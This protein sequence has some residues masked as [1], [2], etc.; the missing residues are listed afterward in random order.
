MPYI[1]AVV[2]T[3]NRTAELQRL[4]ESVLSNG[5]VDLELIIVDQNRNFLIDTLIAEYNTRLNILH[6]KMEEANQSKARNYGAS[7]AKGSVLCFPDD[8][9][10]FEKDSIK[11][12]SEYFGTPTAADLLIIHWKQN[13]VQGI[14][15][16]K[17]SPRFIY[18]FKAVGYATYVMFFK[19]E[20]YEALGG[21]M[22]TIGIGKYIGGGEDSE[23]LFRAAK[24]KFSIRYDSEID[25][26][27]IYIPVY[28]RDLPIIRARQRAMGLMY[29][30]YPVSPFVIFK[31][32]LSPFIKMITAARPE[33]K[34]H[35]NAGVG[36]VQGF[37]HGFTNSKLLFKK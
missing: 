27:H 4:F 18:S 30:R 32:M 21:F 34:K 13:P 20:K 2:A 7:L 22:Q 3:L 14:P 29:Y 31:G 11:K 28:N 23:L 6:V 25:V 37:L 35:Y 9:C 15:S 33:K 5:K 16:G 8:D 17:L 24:E 12:V 36:R 19:R 10:W 26:N 1:S